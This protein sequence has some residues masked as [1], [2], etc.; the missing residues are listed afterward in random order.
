MKWKENT[1]SASVA[2]GVAYSQNAICSLHITILCGR[3]SEGIRF[4]E[5]YFWVF[6]VAHTVPW[7]SMFADDGKRHKQ[8]N[9]IEETGLR[10]M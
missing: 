4:N 7:L 3:I 5:L 10:R 2:F 9:P 6:G 8:H 1:E